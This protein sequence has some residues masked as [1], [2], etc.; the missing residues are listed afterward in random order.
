MEKSIQVLFQGLNFTNKFFKILDAFKSR[1]QNIKS[2][3]RFML[4]SQN[5]FHC[6][7]KY[8][9]IV[10]NSFNEYKSLKL[11][12][13]VPNQ[14]KWVQRG[15]VEMN[16]NFTEINSNNKRFLMGD[17]PISFT[18]NPPKKQAFNQFFNKSNWEQSLN[19]KEEIDDCNMP[20]E[21]AEDEEEAQK[22]IDIILNDNPEYSVN[23]IKEAIKDVRRRSFQLRKRITNSFE[24]KRIIK[25]LNN[26]VWEKARISMKK[27]NKDKQLK[28]E[29][30]GD[31]D[32]FNSND[33]SVD[34]ADHRIKLVNLIIDIKT[35]LEEE[36]KLK[37]YWV[38]IR[39]SPNPNPPQQPSKNYS[40]QKSISNQ[41]RSKSQSRHQNQSSKIHPK[42]EDPMLFQHQ[43]QSQPHPSFPLHHPPP[44]SYGH[45]GPSYMNGF[46]GM[47]GS[48]YHMLPPSQYAPP[49]YYYMYP[50]QFYSQFGM[51]QMGHWNQNPNFN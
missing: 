36:M 50:P 51:P 33:Q 44:Y 27:R 40:N 4:E 34:D 26:T 25:Q 49:Q 39:P 16:T 9:Q 22:I 42:V 17:K 41:P 15:F 7:Y 12:E 10:L 5:K 13:Q 31:I 45:M 6:F 11:P 20:L 32:I 18:I 1:L 8:W 43:H 48:S 19:V 37:N 14:D 30:T 2:N 23:E 28:S 24:R 3:E 46:H 29:S 38:Q 47:P 21:S 35:Q